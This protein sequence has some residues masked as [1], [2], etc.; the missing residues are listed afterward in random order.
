MNAL[1]E[2][3]VKVARSYGNSKSISYASWRDVGVPASTLKS[4]GINRRD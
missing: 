1:E 3:F 2:T 4:A